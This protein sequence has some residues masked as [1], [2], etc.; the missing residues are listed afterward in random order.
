MSLHSYLGKKLHTVPKV[1][2][3]ALIL[4]VIVIS[5]SSPPA[6][7]QAS[8][9]GPARV[10]V[11]FSPGGTLDVVTRALAEQLR[12]PLHRSVIVENKPGAGGRIATDTLLSAPADGS[13]AMLCPDFLKSI[14]PFVFR[15]LNYEPERDILPVSTVVEFP[16]ALAV[17]ASSPIKTFAEFSQWMRAHPEK[18]HFGH[19]AS[20][21]PTHFLGLQIGK[22]IGVPLEDIPFPGAAPMITNLMGGNIAAG[23]ST[24]GDFAQHHSAGKLRVLAVTSPHRSPLLPDVPT[25]S[26]LGRKEL[27]AVGVLA[28]CL[29]PSASPAAASEWSTAVRKAIA[30]ESFASKIRT[31]GFVNTGSS[32]AE[33]STKFNEMRDF[34]EPIIK[35]SGFK[36]D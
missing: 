21:G 10:L 22:M 17:P 16:M 20:G 11:G 32:P 1:W 3:S 27:T 33:A 35:A 6:L 12:D 8:A 19:A 4:L 24:V 14:Y 34:W 13:V 31:L 9:S 26:E 25:F 30:T 23:T 18:A 28:I 36:A 29:P 2:Q 5:T 15:K 7:A